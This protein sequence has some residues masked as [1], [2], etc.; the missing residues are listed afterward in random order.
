[1][2]KDFAEATGIDIYAEKNQGLETVFK[3]LLG[4]SIKNYPSN[5]DVGELMNN[6]RIN[7]YVDGVLQQVELETGTPYFYFKDFKLHF[8]A[9]RTPVGPPGREAQTRSF[10]VPKTEG[11]YSPQYIAVIEQ[12]LSD[13]EILLSRVSLTA[14]K[15]GFDLDQ[16]GKK[17]AFIS[18]TGTVKV[19]EDSYNTFL[20]KNLNTNVKGFNVG[21]ADKPY[22]A[23][24]VQPV[25]EFRE[26]EPETQFTAKKEEVVIPQE[27]DFNQDP[28][29]NTIWEGFKK[30]GSWS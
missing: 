23:T 8:G 11:G 21:T 19:S 7:T 29:P 17:M 2:V 25:I 24:V 30:W 12:A 18:Q 16:K 5:V 20:L 13:F 6:E 22:Y 14:A 3:M 27:Q 28:I 9:V 15:Q 4:N 1:M 26:L 10:V